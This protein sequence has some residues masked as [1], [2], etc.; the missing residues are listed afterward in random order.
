MAPKFVSPVHDM[1]VPLVILFDVLLATA[2]RH[3]GEEATALGRLRAGAGPP[4]AAR[5]SRAAAP[6]H[7]QELG[8]RTSSRR[9]IHSHQRWGGRRALVKEAHRVGGEQGRPPRQP[10]APGAARRAGDR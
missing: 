10:V 4:R 2:G 6:E 5:W 3:I 9:E 7:G 8:R 1:W